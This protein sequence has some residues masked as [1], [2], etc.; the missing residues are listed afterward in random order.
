MLFE[1][2]RRLAGYPW[3][4]KLLSVTDVNAHIDIGGVTYTERALHRRFKAPRNG[5]ADEA[6]G[7]RDRVDR[8]V[9]TVDAARPDATKY[10]IRIP[11]DVVFLDTAYGWL[12]DA[13]PLI[14][15]DSDIAA[16]ELAQLLR[17]AYF[18]PSDD[19]DADSYDSQSNQ[20]DDAALHL[21]L[22][23]VATADEATRTAI[24]QAVYRE[25]HWLM[26]KDRSVEITVRGDR[27]DVTLGPL[28]GSNPPPASSSAHENPGAPRSP[29]DSAP[30]CG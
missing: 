7:P 27:I 30:A 12:T 1:A 20:F 19:P 28:A 29:A 24:A 16:D 21:A 15:A 4:D 26:P 13:C 5:G 25:I 2:D 3:Y 6:F 8:I 23:H 18:C 11:T 9:V 17:R 22:K 14:A 10:S